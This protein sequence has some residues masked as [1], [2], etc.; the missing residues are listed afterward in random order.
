MLCDVRLG[1]TMRLQWMNAAM[2]MM[3]TMLND[4]EQRY[5]RIMCEMHG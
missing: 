2:S 1:N 4:A 5:T 3:M